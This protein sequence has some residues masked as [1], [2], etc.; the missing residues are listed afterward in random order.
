M[1]EPAMETLARRLG[2]VEREREGKK[3]SGRPRRLYI[4]DSPYG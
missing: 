4:E 2:R 3:W 1:N